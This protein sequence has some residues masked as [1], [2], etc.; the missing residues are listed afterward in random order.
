MSQP[1]K[2]GKYEVLAMLGRGGMGV[3]YKAYN[4]KLD[5]LVAIKMMTVG[6]AE[7]PE[8]LQRFYREAQATAS[9]QHPNIVTVYDLGEQD[10]SPYLVM[11]YLEGESLE[12]ILASGRLLRAAE[13]IHYVLEAC[14]GLSYAHGRGI[15]HRDIK[16]AN[17][18]ILKDGGVKLVD[19]GIAHIASNTLTRTGQMMGSLNYMS[20][21]QVEGSVDAR[22]DIF[23]LGVVLYQVFTNRLPFQGGSTASTLRK[24]LHDPP[25]PLA[26][27]LTT[28]PKE[29]EAIILHALAKNREERY[30]SADELALDLLQVHEQ[31]KQELVSRHLQEAEALLES[32]EFKRSREQLQQALRLDQKHTKAIK[33]LRQVQQQIDKWE[34][35]EQARQL[36]AAVEECYLRGDFETAL[37]HLDQAT[38]SGLTLNQDLLQLR[39]RVREARTKAEALQFSLRRAEQAYERGDLDDA[40]EAV[41]E[42]LE[43]NPDSTQA[44]ALYRIIHR[45]WVERS[46]QRQLET[47]LQSARKEIGQNNLTAALS[48]LKQ[49]EGLDPEGADVR[50]LMDEVVAAREQQARRRELQQINQDIEEALNREDYEAASSKIAEGLRRFPLDRTLAQ[51]KVLADRQRLAAQRK[52]F[53][54]EQMAAARRLL[55][56]GQAPEALAV[57]RSATQRVPQEPQL[58]SLLARVQEIVIRNQHEQHRKEV[59][60]ITRGVEQALTEQD[61]EVAYHKIE[62]GLRQF[63]EDAALGQLKILVS[64]QHLAAKARSDKLRELLQ[65]AEMAGD[66]GDL[67]KAHR[68][69]EEAL[70]IDRKSPEARSLYAIISRQMAERDKQLKLQTY[71]GEARRQIS[72]HHFTAA[73][74]L[75]RQAESID[76]EAPGIRELVSL[77]VAGQQE[78]KRRQVLTRLTSEI[79]DALKRDNLDKACAKAEEA[80]R[81]YPDDGEL[82]RLK[83]V[84]DQQRATREQRI[85]VEG[86]VSLAQKL[87]EERKPSAAVA[88]L[89]EALERYPNELALQSMFTRARESVER[90]RIEQKKAESFQKAKDAIRS[91]DYKQAISL[92]EAARRETQSSDFEELLQFA[93]QEA[94][95]D[96][97][98]HRID[99]VAKQARRLKAEE[100]YEEAIL[101]L[102]ATLQET[103]SQELEILLFNIR[104]QVEEFN[105]RVQE[106]ISN[107][108]RLLAQERYAEAVKFLEALPYAKSPQ[109]CGALAEA[110]HKQ[111]VW[112]AVW[113]AQKEVRAAISRS[114]LEEAQTLW[115]KNRDQLGDTQDIRGLAREIEAKRREVANAKLETALRDARV[116][117]SIRSFD[118]AL[119]VLETASTLA[120]NA[121]PELTQQFNAFLNAARARAADQLA[122]VS[123]QEPNKERLVRDSEPEGTET[124]VFGSSF[125]SLDTLD[126]DDETQ[127]TQPSHLEGILGEVTLIADR[128]RDDSNVRGAI[129]EIKNKIT[130]R[131][132]A[133]HQAEL[134]PES[135]HGAMSPLPPELSP[136]S[137]VQDVAVSSEPASI[138]LELLRSGPGQGTAVAPSAPLPVDFDRLSQ[139]LAET[140][141]EPMVEVEGR[142]PAAPVQE[143][144]SKPL[145]EE[146]SPTAISASFDSAA[147]SDLVEEVVLPP[148]DF[149]NETALNAAL[150]ERLEEEE[151]IA[152]SIAFPRAPR[153]QRAVDYSPPSITEVPPGP[154]PV[155]PLD[156]GV[157]PPPPRPRAPLLRSPAVVA[158]CA[159][160]MVASVGIALY[161]W[162]SHS[163]APVAPTAS[164]LTSSSPIDPIQARQQAA[165]DAADKLVAAGDLVGAQ[166]E[167]KPAATLRGPL[168]ATVQQRLAGIEAA[169]QDQ[170]L[171]ALRQQEEQLWQHAIAHVSDGNF[172][173]AR[174]QFQQILNLREGGT[175]KSEARQ[176]LD[177]ILPFREREYGL[178]EQAQ[179]ESSE[180]NL[181]DLQHASG[182]LDQVIALNGPHKA[183]ATTLRAKVN[184]Q[185]S[186]LQKQQGDRTIAKLQAD[187]VQHIR[188]GDFAGARQD[189]QEIKTLGGDAASLSREIDQAENAQI[190]DNAFQQTQQKVEEAL[191]SSDKTRLESSLSELQAMEQAGGPHASEARNLSKQV[192]QKLAA[193]SLPSVP[194]PKKTSSMADE[195][196]VR[197]ALL[198]FNMAFQSGRPR[199]VK[200][201]WPRVDK[202]YTDAIQAGGGYGFSMA[203]YPQGEIQI[204][205]DS[206]VVPCQ[207]V[208]TTT[209][210]DG[211]AK[212]SKKSVKV[213][214]N[215]TE[216]GWLIF[217]AL[218]PN[219]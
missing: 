178:F 136:E 37:R 215:K 68:S 208:S 197:E 36:K 212:Q 40:K 83:A 154:A 8:L 28:Y 25:P 89:Q 44:K 30:Q 70:A 75:L 69:V 190:A 74:Q 174:N 33:L 184:D 206:A 2:I 169:M 57:L 108:N 34:A 60:Q 132:T 87:L 125:E 52:A 10:G 92:L 9:L 38:S 58:E 91:Q 7:D 168:N 201:I 196:A 31:L 103:A 198:R 177:E 162:K 123:Q 53:V 84:A 172:A 130:S 114:A 56:A 118:S 145:R 143:P 1:A 195:A 98:R 159:V 24:I 42:A 181:A 202:K 150:P 86:K 131:L 175:R 21:E 113:A 139:T 5:S 199:D 71:I 49:A 46:R 147:L 101:L 137:T 78:E 204:A 124:Q 180:T 127:V 164:A 77:A 50:A 16:P 126:L 90:E 217:D 176:Y 104:R 117:L 119:P 160:V 155:S 51:L 94:V 200:A 14:H 188:K 182:L 61:Y 81:S 43:I 97:K 134:L 205:G 203:L 151:G 140:T 112:Q 161:V 211:E 66:A 54:R 153:S 158:T 192:M 96:A 45:D 122:K 142:T 29:I 18:M 141:H 63:P 59:E 146:F 187:A 32:G 116:L 99:S 210:P 191:S 4:P 183:D 128:Y 26:Q 62:A 23:S 149:Q 148:P 144:Q 157:K 72:S 82:K 93:R 85:Y 193:L 173:S 35:A 171:R 111:Q 129:D 55:D 20:P 115:Q 156:I 15:V 107:A 102:E 194:P 133:L 152:T 213:T 219:Q 106:A 170:N 216:N 64:E 135:P 19:F 185:I 80:L 65:Q 27:F 67:D 179:R 17:I 39:D 189:A 3:V 100:K 109:F 105:H 138:D 13:K 95:E 11:Q 110:R 209:K 79:E 47:L 76:P 214:L 41:D 120:A 6:H 163:P 218:T 207:L 22:T 121:D 167:L 186:I 165:I 73:L 12:A 88:C 166:H 48:L